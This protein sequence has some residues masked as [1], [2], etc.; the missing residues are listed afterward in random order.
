ML[1]D[2]VSLLARYHGIRLQ[3]GKLLRQIQCLKK[4]FGEMKIQCVNKGTWLGWMQM[5][6]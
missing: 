6:L 2:S 5:I 4:M 3:G 1:L